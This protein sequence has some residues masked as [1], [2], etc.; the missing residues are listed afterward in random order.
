MVVKN[1]LAIIKLKCICYCFMLN[2]VFVECCANQGENSTLM[3][4]QDITL[5]CLVATKTIRSE[6]NILIAV[7]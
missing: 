7:F 3:H 6:N 2:Y 1:V 4:L 5:S